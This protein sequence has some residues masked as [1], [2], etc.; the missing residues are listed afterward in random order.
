MISYF[1]TGF[2]CAR[3]KSFITL[4]LFTEEYESCGKK[5]DL[6]NRCFSQVLV[7]ENGLRLAEIV[8]NAH[9]MIITFESLFVLYTKM[10]C[11][12]CRNQ[13][14]GFFSPYQIKERAHEAKIAIDGLV[15][16]SLFTSKASYEVLTCI[17]I[18]EH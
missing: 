17:Q 8:K 7:Q 5:R 16:P 6:T 11:L 13:V 15:L 2:S 14:L 3:P 12:S 1:P 4:M 9:T 10:P 18:I